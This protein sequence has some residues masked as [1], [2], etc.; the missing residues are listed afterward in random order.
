M[1]SLRKNQTL[2]GN[3]KECIRRDKELV[4]W[5]RS[6]P[7]ISKEDYHRGCTEW[8]RDVED[9]TAQEITRVECEETIGKI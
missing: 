8:M 4:A 1:S 6:L 7:P 5:A 2:L 3:S 9:S